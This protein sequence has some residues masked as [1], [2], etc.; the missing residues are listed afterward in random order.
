MEHIPSL[1]SEEENEEIVKLPKIEEVRKRYFFNLNGSS[2]CGP[3]D[4]TRSFYQTCWDI[5]GKDITRMARTFFRRQELK[6]FVTRTNFVLLPNKEMVKTFSNL[7][8]ISFEF[9]C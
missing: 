8:P 5:I 3:D 6:K 9:L 1:I 7:R 4:F 2:A